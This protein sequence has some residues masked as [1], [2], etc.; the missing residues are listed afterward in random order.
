MEL[1]VLEKKER[2]SAWYHK[3]VSAKRGCSPI[4][5]DSETSLNPLSLSSSVASPP[6]SPVFVVSGRSQSTTARPSFSPPLTFR[7]PRRSR[8][9]TASSSLSPPGTFHDP[10]QSKSITASPP[11][12]P[13]FPCQ[14]E[15]NNHTTID[16]TRQN[17]RDTL[18]LSPESDIG[19]VD[20]PTQ[21][22]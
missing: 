13:S 18:I 19:D 6:L 15:Q 4:S 21:N 11:L 8:Y 2:K 5:S 22:F 7:D 9:T 3:K 14:P 16:L 17:S 20:S 12:S 10:R 1:L